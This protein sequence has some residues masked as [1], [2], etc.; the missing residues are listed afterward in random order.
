LF[1]PFSL[2]YRSSYSV[3]PY[4]R[5]F[6]IH[7]QDNYAQAHPD[8]DFAETFAVWLGEPDQWRSEYDGWP[9]LKK[10]EYVGY[11]MRTYCNVKAPNTSMEQPWAVDRLRSTLQMYYDRKRRDLGDDYSGYFDG[12]LNRIFSQAYH[13]DSHK[14]VRASRFLRSNRRR[15]VDSV[16]LWTGRRKYDIDKLTGKCIQRCE[17]LGLTVQRNEADVLCDFTCFISTVI[18]KTRRLSE[19][20]HIK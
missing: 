8:E 20:V 6:V 5:R 10:L 16:G 11:L 18:S 4:S 13:H 12:P 1:G 19:V 2:P 15:I 7:L 17:E 9:A 14:T 3:Q